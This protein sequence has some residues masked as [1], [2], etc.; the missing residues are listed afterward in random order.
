M[1]TVD[2]SLQHIWVVHYECLK[3]C[4]WRLKLLPKRLSLKFNYFLL[5][6]LLHIGNVWLQSSKIFLGIRI[7]RDKNINSIAAFSIIVVPVRIIVPRS[8]PLVLVLTFMHFN[9]T[10]FSRRVIRFLWYQLWLLKPCFIV[11]C[12]TS[13]RSALKNKFP[14]SFSMKHVFRQASWAHE[15]WNHMEQFQ[16]SALP[17]LIRRLL[18]SNKIGIWNFRP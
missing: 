6:L 14:Q 12:N 8:W 16:D 10:G 18:I 1:V 13:F 15:H 4:E 9:S 3:V 11:S 7:I 5:L 2:W 17:P